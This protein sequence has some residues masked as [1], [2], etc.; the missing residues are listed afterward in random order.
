MDNVT[1]G[2]LYLHCEECEYGW[3]NPAEAADPEK[4]FLTLTMEYEA[5]MPT[6]E[7]IRSSGWEQFIKGSANVDRSSE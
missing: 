3:A 4:R 5:G 6:L 2:Q 7:R 1:T